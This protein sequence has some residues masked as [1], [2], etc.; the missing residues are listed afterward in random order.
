MRELSPGQRKQLNYEFHCNDRLERA[1]WTTVALHDKPPELPFERQVPRLFRALGLRNIYAWYFMF[2]ARHTYDVILQRHMTFD[3]FILAFGW[4]IPC[5]VTVH[6][7]KAIEE[8]PL[9]KPG[10][11][12]RL[13]A[14]VERRMGWI[15]TRQ[16]LGLLGVTADIAAYEAAAHHA[17]CPQGVYPNGILVDEVPVLIDRRGAGIEVGFVCGKFTAWHG[18]DRLME[19]VEA[20]RELAAEVGLK[21]HLIGQ[22]DDEQRVAVDAINRHGVVFV[23]HGRLSEASYFQILE[24]CDLGLGSLALDRQ[25]MREGSTLKVREYLAVGLPVYSGQ[26]DTALPEGFAYYRHGAAEVRAILDF[27]RTMKAETREAVRTA[28]RSYIEKRALMQNVCTWL[29]RVVPAE[30]E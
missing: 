5:R 25:N 19:A 16:V 30:A 17:E 23:V 29:A 20:E 13:A 18:L 15:N 21:V 11:R 27:A 28:S 1:A 7:G 12:G 22:L 9:I 3:P 14:A 8:L 2:R 26:P 24:T 6:H 10:W 4:L